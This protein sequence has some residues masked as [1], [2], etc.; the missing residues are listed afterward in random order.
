MSWWGA[1]QPDQIRHH[2]EQLRDGE[3]EEPSG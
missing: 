2:V 1:H 3:D